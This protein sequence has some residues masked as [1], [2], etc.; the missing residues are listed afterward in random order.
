MIDY[1]RR[2]ETERDLAEVSNNDLRCPAAHLVAPGTKGCLKLQSSYYNLIC[3]ECNQLLSIL[4]IIW[5]VFLSFYLEPNYLHT[6]VDRHPLS[7]TPPNMPSFSRLHQTIFRRKRIFC[8]NPSV[9]RAP[10]LR[11]DS[12]PGGLTFGWKYT[13]ATLITSTAIYGALEY[14]LSGRTVPE[15]VEAAKRN[16]KDNTAEI[17]DK[18]QRSMLGFVQAGKRNIEDNAEKRLANF[19]KLCRVLGIPRTRP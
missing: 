10:A 4:K 6:P 5:P 7:I 17:I 16:I 12:S 2:G 8:S 11:K 19:Q 1:R 18:W 13:G 3:R 15:P 9:G 14:A